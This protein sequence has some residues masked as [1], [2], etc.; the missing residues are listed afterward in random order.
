MAF[1]LPETTSIRDVKRLYNELRQFLDAT[2]ATASPAT[3]NTN[4]F[5]IDLSRVR[6]IDTPVLQLLAIVNE[7]ALRRELSLGW[8]QPSQEFHTTL[9]LSGLAA[10]FELQPTKH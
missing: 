7:E 2:P 4:N 5:V 8:Q 6:Q 9:V 1:A 3:D 10:G